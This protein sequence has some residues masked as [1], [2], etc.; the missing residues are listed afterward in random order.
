MTAKMDALMAQLWTTPRAKPASRPLGSVDKRAYAS[1]NSR[2]T[3]PADPQL[4]SA[5][6]STAFPPLQQPVN[7]GGMWALKGISPRAIAFP[8]SFSTY[9]SEN[10]ATTATDPFAPC[11]VLQEPMMS[12]LNS[13]VIVYIMNMVS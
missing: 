11:T 12:V 5:Y 10:M 8:Y 13:I 6:D 3:I 2:A 7:L 9:T 4:E 1:S